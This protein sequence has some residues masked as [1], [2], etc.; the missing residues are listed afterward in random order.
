MDEKYVKYGVIVL[1]VLVVIWL[2]VKYSKKAEPMYDV[3]FSRIESEQD[4]LLQQPEQE[5]PTVVRTALGQD[6]SSDRP[7]FTGSSISFP[8][9][10]QD[11]V[12]MD[13]LPKSSVDSEGNAT[14]DLS[15]RNYL[16][17]SSAFGIDTVG[18]TNKNASLDIRSQP[19]IPVN[20]AVSPW[21]VSSYTPDLFRKEFNIGA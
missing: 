11:V 5:Q 2:F 14:S 16:T 13:L 12:P 19:H 3:E 15:A 10:G 6:L 9:G 1:I 18:S 17:S 4:N 20:M 8:T 7:E 21:N